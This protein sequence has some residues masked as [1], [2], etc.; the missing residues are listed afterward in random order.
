[1]K[2]TNKKLL[3]RLIVGIGVPVGMAFVA[4]FFYFIK[5]SPPCIFYQLTGLH[6]PGCGSGRMLLALMNFEFYKAFRYQPLLFISLPVIAYYLLK[7]YI[8]FVFGKD[9][10]PFFEIKS[11]LVA[12]SIPTVIIAYWILRNIPIFPFNLLA[13]SSI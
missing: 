1:M 8:K 12:I 11:K 2:G 3:L 6:C 5:S 4:L 9:V 10:L 13:P 7:V